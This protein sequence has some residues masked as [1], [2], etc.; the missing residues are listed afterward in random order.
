VTA[1]CAPEAA[2]L[3]NRA[4]AAAEPGDSVWVLPVEPLLNVHAATSL[5]AGALA[6]LRARAA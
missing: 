3:V 5:W 1:G 4:L 2:R 6:R